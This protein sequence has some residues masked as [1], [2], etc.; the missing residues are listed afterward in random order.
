MQLLGALELLVASH[1]VERFSFLVFLTLALMFILCRLLCLQAATMYTR[2][3]FALNP[4][5]PGC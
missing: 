1:A 4:G 2:S 5:M 3:D